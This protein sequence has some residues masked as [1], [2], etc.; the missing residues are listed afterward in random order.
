MNLSSGATPRPLSSE[1]P[2]STSTPRYFCGAGKGTI[3]ADDLSQNLLQQLEAQHARG[4][5]AYAFLKENPHLAGGLVQGQVR[6]DEA[7]YLD[8]IHRNH[9]ADALEDI[10]WLDAVENKGGT[11]ST[12]VRGAGEGAPPS[13]QWKAE[14]ISLVCRNFFLKEVKYI[15]AR[16]E[17]QKQSGCIVFVGQSK[18]LFRAVAEGIGAAFNKGLG[19]GAGEIGMNEKH[20]AAVSS[21]SRIS[22]RRKRT[23]RALAAATGEEAEDGEDGFRIAAVQ[24]TVRKITPNH[25]C[26][27]GAKKLGADIGN[28]EGSSSCSWAGI[29]GSVEDDLPEEQG[30]TSMLLRPAKAAKTEG[31]GR[32]APGVVEGSGSSCSFPGQDFLATGHCAGQ[33]AQMTQQEK[34]KYL[35]QCLPE[36]ELQPSL[37]LVYLPLKPKS[38]QQVEDLKTISEIFERLP[39]LGAA[40]GQ[41]QQQHGKTT[42]TNSSSSAA[43]AHHSAGGMAGLEPVVVS[44]PGGGGGSVVSRQVDG[45]PTPGAG[46]S[47]SSISPAVVPGILPAPQTQTTFFKAGGFERNFVYADDA[48]IF[49]EVAEAGID[50]V[51]GNAYSGYVSLVLENVSAGILA[52][53]LKW[54]S[55][56]SRGGVALSEH[57]RRNL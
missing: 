15:R 46:L 14:A 11:T 29:G 2:G 6:V 48:Q 1:P 55:Y 42:P 5:D 30:V 52:S 32:F 28:A 23:S 57:D 4:Q 47:A 27:L 17:K 24:Y 41:Q 20:A 37:S 19:R 45:T 13:K 33:C 43:G 56:D 36:P 34:K 12:Y 18:D 25:V 21:S 39:N 44:K 31:G 50:K 38:Q 7:L 49:K 35:L 54:R 10:P 40:A 8:E 53:S 22:A 16:M 26:V 9:F 3:A 51:T